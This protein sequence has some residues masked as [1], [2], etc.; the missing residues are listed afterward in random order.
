MSPRQANRGRVRDRQRGDRGGGR[1]LGG[2]RRGRG[3][4]VAPGQPGR[5]EKLQHRPRAVE[6]P[7]GLR[8][9]DS[10]AGR[11]HGQHVRLIAVGR[12]RAGANVDALRPVKGLR[13]ELELQARLIGDVLLKHCRQLGR[14]LVMQ[15]HRRAGKLEC[16]RIRPAGG[17]LHLGWLRQEPI[18]NVARLARRPPN[19]GRH[20]SPTRAMPFITRTSGWNVGR[21]T[22]NVE[23]RKSNNR[24]ALRFRPNPPWTARRRGCDCWRGF[25]CVGSAGSTGSAEVSGVWRF[26]CP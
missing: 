7:R 6:S 26:R 24:A 12:V 13:R 10:C 19:L 14:V 2:P 23:R 11:R 3:V 5:H 22:S 9:A 15:D 21:R 17:Q 4:G 16:S 8:C 1:G 25:Y 18:A 20:E